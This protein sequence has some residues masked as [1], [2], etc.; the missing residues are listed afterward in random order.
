MKFNG[1]IATGAWTNWSDFELDPDDSP[2]PGTG[3]SLHRTFAFQRDIWRSYGRISMK[4][5]PWGPGWIDYIL[6]WIRIIV[7]ILCRWYMHST[8]CPSSLYTVCRRWDEMWLCYVVADRCYSVIVDFVKVHD[9][10]Y[11]S[12]M[13]CTFT[14]DIRMLSLGTNCTNHTYLF[15]ASEVTTSAS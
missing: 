1:S 10:D 4:S 12:V 3:F 15:T 7:R 14:V 8:E 9:L 5:G 6:S 2:D 11:T 13:V